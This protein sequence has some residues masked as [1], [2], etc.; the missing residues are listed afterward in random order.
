MEPWCSGTTLGGNANP[1]ANGTSLRKGIQC[2]VKC[3]QS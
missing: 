3:V 2:K 1:G